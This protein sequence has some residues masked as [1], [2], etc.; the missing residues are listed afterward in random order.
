[1][2]HLSGIIRICLNCSGESLTAAHEKVNIG[3]ISSSG[4]ILTYFQLVFLRPT[5][6]SFSVR[7]PI[8]VM[9]SY[10]R[11]SSINT[12]VLL[13]QTIVMPPVVKHFHAVKLVEWMFSGWYMT[14]S[15]AIICEIQCGTAKTNYLLDDVSFPTWKGQKTSMFKLKQAYSQRINYLAYWQEVTALSVQWIR[16]K[17]VL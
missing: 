12:L 11:I 5:S 7:T 8:S 3:N 2:L 14:Q 9:S 4:N 1:M 6:C 10:I 15:L 17:L 13:W 16:K